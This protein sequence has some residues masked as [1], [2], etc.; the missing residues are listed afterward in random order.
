M[1]RFAEWLFKIFLNSM[2][3]LIAGAVT[4]MMLR[5]LAGASEQASM[6][7]AVIMGS[8]KIWLRDEDY[9]PKVNP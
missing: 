2:S 7:G 9:R 5:W 8:A 1:S 6:Y 3:A 4:Y